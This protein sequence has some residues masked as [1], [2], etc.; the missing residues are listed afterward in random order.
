MYVFKKLDN[1]KASYNTHTHTC[2]KKEINIKS[3]REREMVCEFSREGG[4]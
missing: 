1:G 3:Q 4:K 2:R